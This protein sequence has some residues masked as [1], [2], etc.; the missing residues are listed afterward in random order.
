[1]GNV[2]READIFADLSTYRATGQLGL[3]AMAAGC[4]AILPAEGATREF[5]SDG[6]DSLVVDTTNESDVLAAFERLITGRDTLARLQER[7]IRTGRCNSMRKTIW[8]ELLLLS[9]GTDGAES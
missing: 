5:A 9:G 3:E 4:A 8:S 1:M 6:E 2:L 7:A